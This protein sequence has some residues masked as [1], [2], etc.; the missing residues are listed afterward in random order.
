[1]CKKTFFRKK[2]PYLLL[3]VM[4]AIML[5]GMSIHILFDNPLRILRKELSSLEKLELKR[6]ADL[7]FAIVK[8]N[9]YANTI[10]WDDITHDGDHKFSWEN[11]NVEKVKEKF[12]TPYE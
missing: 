8:E 4:I 7:S 11:D 10:Q 5:I 3:E 9:L 2:S 6:M 12:N 1:M